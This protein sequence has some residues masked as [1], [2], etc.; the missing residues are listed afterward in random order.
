[1]P[2]AYIFVVLDCLMRRVVLLVVLLTLFFVKGCI[3]NCYDP[4]QSYS[5][6]ADGLPCGVV[7]F[8]SARESI[9]I[10]FVS[11]FNSRW[12]SDLIFKVR[13]YSFQSDAI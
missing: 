9:R 11:H 3:I 5:N 7:L 1:M 10:L 6:K 4:L 2:L 8:L 12:F 13:K